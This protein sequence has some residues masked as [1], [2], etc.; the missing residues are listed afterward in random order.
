MA[1]DEQGVVTIEI[2]AFSRPGRWFSRLGGP[3]SRA[4]Q[5]RVTDR[6]LFALRDD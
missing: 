3:I 5:S 4:V 2:I 6:Y 1:I